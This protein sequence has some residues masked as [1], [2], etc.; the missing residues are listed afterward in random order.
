[1]SLANTIKKMSGEFADAIHL[2][3]IASEQIFVLAATVNNIKAE[4]TMEEKKKRFVDYDILS[5]TF[6]TALLSPN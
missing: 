3:L 5:S 2:V 4:H 6:L 1:M